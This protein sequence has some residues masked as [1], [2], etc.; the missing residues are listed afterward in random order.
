V[1]PMDQNAQSAQSAWQAQLAANGLDRLR[2]QAGKR[3]IT[4][5]TRR[6]MFLRHGETAGNAQKVFQPADIS[7][8]PRGR[9]QALAAAQVLKQHPVQRI[10]ASTM[11]RAQQTAVIVGDACQLAPH[12]E[13]GLRERSFGDLIGTS[14]AQLDWRISPPNGEDLQDFVARAQAGLEAALSHGKETLLVAHG[15]N[16]YVLAFSLGL[17]LTP[18]MVQNATPLVFSWSAAGWQ[19]SP[20]QPDQGGGA[21]SG[22][23]P[24]NSGW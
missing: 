19:V 16:L 13:P 14:S 2:E 20:M 21:K 17:D 22:L 9:E 8:N 11:V 15:G 3:S 5:S 7:L 6:F 4:V 12:P 10:Y 24:R 1:N 18:D 23:V